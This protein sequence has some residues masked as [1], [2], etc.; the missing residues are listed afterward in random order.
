MKGRI[1][2]QKGLSMLEAVLGV[3][4]ISVGFLGMIPLMTSATANTLSSDHNVTSTFLGEE[5][6]ETL[7]ADKRFRGYNYIVNANYPAQQMTGNLSQYRRS[8]NI[9]EVNAT[10]LTTPQ[11]GSGYKR[12][13]VTVTWNS[14]QSVLTTTLLTNS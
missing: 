12:I 10:D 8:V 9:T 6:A 7:I 14:T 5:L 3:L 11:A 4:V 2:N 13:D 1:R